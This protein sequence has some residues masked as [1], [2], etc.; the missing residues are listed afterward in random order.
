M[1]RRRR[2][3]GRRQAED[4]AIWGVRPRVCY[5]RKKKTRTQ[6]Q[7]QSGAF[8]FFVFLKTTSACTHPLVPPVLRHLGPVDVHDARPAL[9]DVLVRR[10]HRQAH[11]RQRAPRPK[12]T[13]RSPAPFTGIRVCGTPHSRPAVS[14][15]LREPVVA[16][17][18]AHAAPIR[19]GALGEVHGGRQRGRHSVAPSHGRRRADRSAGGPVGGHAGVTPL[20]AIVPGAAHQA[21]RVPRN[22]HRAEEVGRGSPRNEAKRPP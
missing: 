15:T 1:R 13:L 8:C 18:V 7:C 14:S 4:H 16:R 6:K 11:A 2:G 10:A 9:K 19:P 12:R 3:M 17:L 22:K 5:K 20:P 21:R